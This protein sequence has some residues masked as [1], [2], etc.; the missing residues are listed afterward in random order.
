MGCTSGH[1][2]FWGAKDNIS[3]PLPVLPACSLEARRAA[4]AAFP[5]SS[6]LAELGVGRWEELELG[7][8]SWELLEL[9]L[10]LK[11]KAGA[12]RKRVGCWVVTGAG[13]R[14]L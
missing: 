3:G 14:D 1:W 6:G 4:A 8:G 9:E 7:A 11:K 13:C 2:P 5:P 12:S 10:G